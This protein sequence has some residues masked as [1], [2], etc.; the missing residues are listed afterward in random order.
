MSVL[1]V[2][3]IALFGLAAFWAA[4][5][6]NGQAAPHAAVIVAVVLA[7]LAAILLSVGR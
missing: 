6:S 5:R 1:T 3:G 2:L 7:G 4:R